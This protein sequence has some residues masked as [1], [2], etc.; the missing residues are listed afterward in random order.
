RGNR[1]EARQRLIRLC[2]QFLQARTCPGGSKRAHQGRLAGS[3]ILAR[4][5]AER[6]GVA[7][8][9]EQVVGNLESL[10]DRRAIAINTV[11]RSGISLA[12]DCAA[13]AGKADQRTSF[14]RL[15]SC[16]FYLAQRAF[17]LEAA[18][19]GEIKHLSAVHSP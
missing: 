18:F 10:A 13:T 5:F 17:L 15:Q 6:F 7:L 11:K 16:N 8:D 12:E 2:D 9:I 14:H 1:A 19:R 3:R 4:S